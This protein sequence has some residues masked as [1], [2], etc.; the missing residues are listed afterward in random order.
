MSASP[1]YILVQFAASYGITATS[2]ITC[3]AYNFTPICD[4]QLNPDTTLYQIKVQSTTSIPLTTNLR[5]SSLTNP[6]TIP[7]DFTWVSTYTSDN[8]K[9]SENKNTIKFTTFCTFPCREC[10][11]AA[12]NVC[13]SCYPS[14][15]TTKIYLYQQQC[16]SSCPAGYN[17][18]N[19]DFVC[20]PCSSPCLECEGSVT[21]CTFCDT[22]TSYKYLNKTNST[23]TCVS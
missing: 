6:S 15:L 22:N 18:D 14:N 21:Y 3:F 5:F 2:L 13:I 23:S 10:Q 20:K 7:S 9:M 19:L 17:E 16:L 12:R 4:L 11:T 8:Y 1:A